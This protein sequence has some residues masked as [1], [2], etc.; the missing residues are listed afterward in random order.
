MTSTPKLVMPEEVNLSEG[1]ATNQRAAASNN[2]RQ[3]DRPIL[4]D[5][6]LQQLSSILNPEDIRPVGSYTISQ[7]EEEYE[8]LILLIKDEREKHAHHVGDLIQSM[9]DRV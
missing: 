5:S 8:R 1:N 9:R 6:S 2:M 4:D 3:V 7:L